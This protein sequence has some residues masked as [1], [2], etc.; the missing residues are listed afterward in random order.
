MQMCLAFFIRLSIVGKEFC[1]QGN[2]R[3]RREGKK[4]KKKNAQSH[5]NCIRLNILFDW[6]S[7]KQIK[8]MAANEEEPSIVVQKY[9]VFFDKSNRYFHHEYVRR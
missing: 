6:F 1:S 9:P 3:K 7:Y 2:S 4:E 5:S 8:K